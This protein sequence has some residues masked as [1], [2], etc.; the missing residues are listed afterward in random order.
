M[1]RRVRVG[2]AGLHAARGQ[3]RRRRGWPAAWLPGGKLSDAPPP[4]CL[5]RRRF[6]L[7]QADARKLLQG[8][9]AQQQ[10]AAI[11]DMNAGAWDAVRRTAFWRRS[12]PTPHACADACSCAPAA[13]NYRP[14][15]GAKPFPCAPRRPARAWL[16]ARRALGLAAYER[17]VLRANGG[18]AAPASLPL[19][20]I[21]PA[22]RAGALR[23]R[24]TQPRLC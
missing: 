23:S 6:R 3:E 10:I 5:T 13:R 15:D 24:M 1:H 7:R 20:A 19:G 8:A 14:V 17:E 21:W 18:V 11:Q 16:L 4:R 9:A 2:T 12:L 22:T